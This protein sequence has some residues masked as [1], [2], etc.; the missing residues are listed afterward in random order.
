MLRVKKV[1]RSLIVYTVASLILLSVI[2]NVIFSNKVLQTILEYENYTWS[3]LS[4]EIYVL[5]AYYEARPVENAPFVRIVTISKYKEEKLVRKSIREFS[6]KSYGADAF[7][8]KCKVIF[9][10]GSVGADWKSPEIVIFDERGELF[11]ATYINCPIGSDDI[12][13]QVLLSSADNSIKI[14]VKPGLGAAGNYNNKQVNNQTAVCVRALYGPYN[15]ANQVGQFINFYSSVLGANMFRFYLLDVTDKIKY[16]LGELQGSSP[17][18]GITIT[19]VDWD[20]PTSLQDWEAV[21]DYG[22]LALLSDCVYSAMEQYGYA[23][24]VDLDEFVVPNMKIPQANTPSFMDLIDQFKRAPVNKSSHSYLFKNSFFCGEFNNETI[25]G[26]ITD[27]NFDI[28]KIP[29]REDFIWSYQLRAKML[30]RTKE[31]VGVGHHMIHSW[32]RGN[33]S[34]NTPVPHQVALLHHYRNCEGVNG[35]FAE[36]GK[37]VLKQN[38]VKD[39]SIYKYKQ[40]LEQ[41]E[42]HQILQN[43]FK[44]T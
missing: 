29:F 30:V 26:S 18:H 22:A 3:R 8:V 37:P 41:T 21:W 7:D 6:P 17:H 36:L 38:R 9:E 20:L 25:N 23:Y 4:D 16:L 43:M 40:L 44:D 39:K 2:S 31:V 15:N 5:S 10:D 32:V 42:I 13:K 1:H 12:P 33:V 35:G 28:F 34:F 19:V 14:P 27:E 11:A 24:I